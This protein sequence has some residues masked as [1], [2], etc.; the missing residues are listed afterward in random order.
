MTM[1]K[2]KKEL[3][4]VI[5][6]EGEK[7]RSEGKVKEKGIKSWMSRKFVKKD[8]EGTD[9]DIE[10]VEWRIKRKEKQF[11]GSLTKKK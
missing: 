2:G 9:I 11:R 8:E 4:K 3:G 1:R 5:L 6:N 10:G 7:L